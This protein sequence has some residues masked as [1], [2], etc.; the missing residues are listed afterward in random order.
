MVD[1]SYLDSRLTYANYKHLD[2]ELTDQNATGVNAI[3][4]PIMINGW[5]HLGIYS[6]TGGYVSIHVN[7]HN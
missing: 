7:A 2:I 4:T 3:A 6:N 5:W 1:L